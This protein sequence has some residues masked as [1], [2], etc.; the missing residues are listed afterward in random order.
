[1]RNIYKT[2]INKKF[3]NEYSCINQCK[4]GSLAMKKVFPELKIQIG[5]ANHIYHCWLI[6]K[7]GNIIDPTAKQFDG[8]I[9]YNLIACEDIKNHKLNKLSNEILTVCYGMGF[10]PNN[11]EF[12][13]TED[14]NGD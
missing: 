13:F 14:I 8:K 11:G 7:E 2:W 1:M 10:F 4:K 5:Y 12:I 6:D 9:N 3:P